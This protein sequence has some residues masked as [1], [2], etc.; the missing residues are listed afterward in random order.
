MSQHTTDASAAPAEAESFAYAWAPTGRR[1]AL[2]TP[3]RVTGSED[4]TRVCD[5]SYVPLATIAEPRF[6]GEMYAADV[7]A[8]SVSQVGSTPALISRDRRLVRADPRESLILSIFLRS[9]G[10]VVQGGLPV[11]LQAGDGY[12]LDSDDPYSVRFHAPYDMLAL[13]LPI[14]SVGVDR[15]AVSSVVGRVLPRGG[16]ELSVLRRHLAL[17]LADGGRGR[18]RGGADEEAASALL[19]E[20][21]GMLVRRADDPEAAT[22]RLS[23]D[24]L[25]AHA[26][27]FMVRHFRDSSFGVDD[28]AREYAVTRRHLEKLFHRLGT[29]PGSHLRDLRLRHASQLLASDRPMPVSEVALRAGFGDVNTLIRTFRRRWG[30]TPLRWRNER[31]RIVAELPPDPRSVALLT[32]LSRFTWT[33]IEP[34]R[35]S[36]EAGLAAS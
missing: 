36:Q 14:A 22:A 32:D 3:L 20:L 25:V 33:S 26:R 13:R 2:W 7:G 27:H 29:S 5:Q 16:H 30:T 31:R 11:R 9:G 10:T 28:V 1:R 18:D 34:P 19:A 4:W 6:R 17:L 24:A 21:T 35:S 12:L 15:R 8:A 23:N